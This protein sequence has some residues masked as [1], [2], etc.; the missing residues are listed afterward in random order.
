M[1]EIVGIDPRNAV[2]VIEA[3]HRRGL[4]E[5]SRDP[6]DRRRQVIRLTV[7][8]RSTIDDLRGAGESIEHELL[9]GLSGREQAQLH[10]LLLKLLDSRTSG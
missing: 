6:A 10:S 9:V 8:G 1:S 3:L 2:A 5:R 7:R 4:L